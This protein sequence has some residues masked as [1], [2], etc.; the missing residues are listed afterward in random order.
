[1]PPLPTGVCGGP[2]CFESSVPECTRAWHACVPESFQHDYL[3]RKWTDFC[4]TLVD[5]VFDVKDERVRFKGQNV[6]AGK[7]L[8][9]SGVLSFVIPVSSE[10]LDGF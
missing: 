8:T 6:K 10:W 1:V 2:L 9:K 3:G 5:D 4:Q 7:D